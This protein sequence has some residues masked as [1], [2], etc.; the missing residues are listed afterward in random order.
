MLSYCYDIIY[1]CYGKK[2]SSN[3]CSTLF[4]RSLLLLWSRY[5]IWSQ[6]NVILLVISTQSP[7]ILFSA[8][9]AILTS[10]LTS[11]SYRPLGPQ[12]VSR[13][14]V[15]QLPHSFPELRQLPSSFDASRT[16]NLFIIGPTWNSN[17]RASVCYYLYYPN[18]YFPPNSRQPISL[19]LLKRRSPEFSFTSIA[20]WHLQATNI[21]TELEFVL[22][23]LEKLRN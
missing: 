17:Q 23:L 11:S 20:F 5:D 8:R 10:N 14:S 13:T 7:E 21:D 2:L 12:F 4:Y 18:G 16:T 1:L 19:V 9:R 15:R 6:S 22:C 3:Y